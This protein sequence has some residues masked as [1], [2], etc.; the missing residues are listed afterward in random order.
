MG[1][2]GGVAVVTLVHG[3]HVHLGRQRE[4]LLRATRRPDLHVVVR[5]DD[6]VE[7]PSTQELPTTTV[8][9]PMSEH[10]LPLA[11]ARNAGAEA[12]LAEGAS[13]LVFLDVDCIPGRELLARYRAAARAEPEALLCGPVAYLPPA[14]EDGY[15]LAALEVHA[16]PHEARP[17]PVP[18]TLERDDAGHALFW[19]LSFAVTPGTWSRLGGFD[20]SYE[21][22]GGEDT[23]F[24]QRARDA[25]VPVVWVGGAHAFHQHHRVSDPPVEHLDDV[26]RNATLFH[27]RWGWWPMAG[28]LEAFEEAGLVERSDGTWRRTSPDRRD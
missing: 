21:G 23:D 4:G 7:V 15:D 12:A 17:D 16:R 25:G 27:E 3:R 5:M 14:G 20:E 11:R 13:T 19:S 10:G 22:Y 26:V 18:G 28:W 9:V 24:A 8:D 1:M 6:D 2:N